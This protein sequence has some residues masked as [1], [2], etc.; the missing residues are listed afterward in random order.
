MWMVAARRTVSVATRGTVRAVVGSQAWQGPSAAR[1]VRVVSIMAVGGAGVLA[2]RR[3]LF[4]QLFD[5]DSFTYTYLLSDTADPTRSCVIIDPV[6]I[7]AERD[8]QLVRELALQPMWLMNTHVH[9]D[10]ITGTGI[11]K[12]RYF[13]DAKSV[14][15]VVSGGKADK[16][17]DHMERLSFGDFEIEARSTPGHTNGCMTY[18]VYPPADQES[19]APVLP[20][21]A[22]TGDALL[23][24]G[25]GRTD[26]Q[27]GS[28]ATLYK[29]VHEQ[30]FTL[31]DD[32]A[33]FPAHDY[34][35]RTVTTVGEEKVHNPRLT[36]SEGRFVDLMATLNLPYPKKIDAS[37]PANLVCGLQD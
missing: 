24:R 32:T 16:Y 11:L 31:P 6:D 36:L 37:L 30:I 19:D 33:L 29:S 28:A 12:T 18:V 13:P 4:R 7:W 10:H 23:I 35:G 34:K 26:F 17:L 8:S 1:A 2:H 25:C 27:Q 14:L 5:E 20:L 9:A 21:M 3:L 15:A 22:F